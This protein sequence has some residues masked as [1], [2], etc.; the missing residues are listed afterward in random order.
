MTWRS[1]R[2]RLG[3]GESLRVGSGEGW[4]S[5]FGLGWLR[6]RVTEGSG[7]FGSG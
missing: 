5:H 6:G 7:D 3:S 4:L 2:L 1:G